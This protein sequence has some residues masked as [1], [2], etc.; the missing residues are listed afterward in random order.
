MSIDR[1]G[2]IP[3][4]RGA[5][6]VELISDRLARPPA[7]RWDSKMYGFLAKQRWRS[8]SARHGRRNSIEVQTV[9]IDSNST[10]EQADFGSY[11]LGG[12][13]DGY[14]RRPNTP[15]KRRPGE[16]KRCVGK[17]RAQRIIWPRRRR[18]SVGW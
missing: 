7:D 18:T 5:G 2:N 12:S 13:A 4:R 9:R 1:L 10:C 16:S 11:C 6:I 8:V 14:V 17:C 3:A 15:W